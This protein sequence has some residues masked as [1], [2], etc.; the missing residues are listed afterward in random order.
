[1]P[2]SVNKDNTK[3][4]KHIFEPSE[5]NLS[6]GGFFLFTVTVSIISELLSVVP[7]FKNTSL[8][9]SVKTLDWWIVFG[10][11]VIIGSK[12]KTDSAV[13]CF[14]FFLIS[15]PLNYLVRAPFHPD[16]LAL[17][18]RYPRWFIATFFTLIMGYIGH[19]IKEDKAVPDPALFHDHKRRVDAAL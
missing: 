5:F 8:S 16:G 10:V 14:L 17:F 13:K 7:A 6:W 15:Q 4:I 11:F 3:T 12:S 2:D 9:D 19:R 18:H 1:M